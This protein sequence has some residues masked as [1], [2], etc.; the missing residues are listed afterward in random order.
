MEPHSLQKDL[1]FLIENGYMLTGVN[2]LKY[3]NGGK[4]LQTTDIKGEAERL[5]KELDRRRKK[6]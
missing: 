5:R 4:T 3:N 1:I 6:W 2:V